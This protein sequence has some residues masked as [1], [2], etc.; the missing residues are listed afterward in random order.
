MQEALLQHLLRIY[1]DNGLYPWRAGLQKLEELRYLHQVFR[2][3]G[4]DEHVAP[5]LSLETW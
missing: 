4:L 5:P 2:A 3:L 1:I